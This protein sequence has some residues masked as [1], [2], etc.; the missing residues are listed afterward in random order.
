MNEFIDLK[1]EERNN[2]N[3]VRGLNDGPKCTTTGE[4]SSRG[5]SISGRV[6]AM[7]LANDVSAATCYV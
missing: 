4:S 2:M 5:Q 6:V 3:G 1:T 7:A